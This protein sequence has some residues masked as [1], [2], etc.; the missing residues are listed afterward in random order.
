MLVEKNP[1]TFGRKCIGT[2]FSDF[3]PKKKSSENFWSK[4]FLGPTFFDFCPK[5]I[6]LKKSMKIQNFEI[7]K[8]IGGKSKFQN[9]EISLTFSTKHFSGKNRK[10]LVPIFFRWDVFGFFRRFFFRQKFLGLPIPIPNDPKIPKITLRTACNHYKNTNSAHE[11]I[12]A[13]F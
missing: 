13:P 6:S 9:F 5:K 4:F 11:K 3:C 7:S 2:F 12:I 10:F 8:K 1:N